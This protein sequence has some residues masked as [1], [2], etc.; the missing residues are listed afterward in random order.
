MTPALTAAIVRVRH[1]NGAI[2]G[3]GFL[4]GDGR[5]LTCAHV[6]ADALGRERSDPQ[7]P[8]AEVFLDFPLLP[9][10]PTASAHVEVWRPLGP[11]GGND[12][13][14]GDI[15]VLELLHP[16]PIAAQ[17][18]RRVGAGN[19]WRRR[20]GAFGFP[21]DSGTYTYGHCLGPQ[22]SGWIHVESTSEY[23][24]EG[25]YSGTPAWDD[26]RDLVI[27]MV[28]ATEGADTVKAG[29]VI[30]ASALADLCPGL[31]IV[32]LAEK[33]GAAPAV[34]VPRAVFRAPPRNSI[35]TGREQLLVNLEAALVSGASTAL[36]QAITGLGGAGKTQVAIEYAHR[37]R[38]HYRVIWWVRAESPETLLE[39]LAALATPLGLS[40]PPDAPPADIAAAVRRALEDNPGWLLVFDNAESLDVVR[41]H[42]PDY[43]HVLITS[44]NRAW[45][46]GAKVIQVDVWSPQEAVTFLLTRTGQS[47]ADGAAALAETL[48]YLPLAL[49]Q[50]G[51]YMEE[52]AASFVRYLHLYRDR[53]SAKLLAQHG[54]RDYA[55]TVATTW[56]L[57][58]DQ[59][60]KASPA[61]AEL[62][63]LCAFLTPEAI[64]EGLFRPEERSILPPG[65]RRADDEAFDNACGVLCRYSLVQ[66]NDGALTLHRLVQEVVRDGLSPQRLRTRVTAGVLLVRTAFPESSDD[67][68][69]WGRCARLLP[70][71]LTVADHAEGMAA[72]PEAT[73]WLL[74]RVATYLWRRAE[75]TPARRLFERALTIDEAAYGP[76]HPSV[77]EHVN[78]LALVLLDLGDLA[79]ARRG[80]ERAL[81][82]H[83]ATYGP[84]HPTVATNINNLALVLKALGHL[85]EARRDLE[86]A[87][88]ID[89]AAYGP[90]HPTVARDVNNLARVLHDLGDMAGAR[91][92]FE[93]ALA[94]DEAAFG[95]DHPSVARDVNNLAVVLRNLG[96]LAKARR[97]AERALAI[98]E[99]A[100]GPDH[101]FV[102]STVDTRA[103]VLRDLG[104]LAGARRGFERALAIHEAAYGPDH[105]SVATDVN[106][107]ARVLQE[108]GDLA[109][110]R[111]GFER[112]L[113]IITAA[114]GPDHPRAV[115]I[116]QNLQALDE[117]PPGSPG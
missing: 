33:E 28:V 92:G 20:F 27:G 94:I 87:L 30:P 15:A 107:L 98:D 46:A 58:F 90:D 48:G 96:E 1:A 31:E 56:R 53:G 86:R 51:A 82:I 63:E 105:P 116:A 104:E 9:G 74:D 54:P 37:H 99:A 8:E 117:D 57:S 5:V 18:I 75:V 93:R 19:L 22:A 89:E 76:D 41:D 85:A 43:G 72:E 66:R 97:C 2:V 36:V 88:A 59:V 103:A 71:A 113:R 64:P 109:G 73:S 67:V 35:F 4:V 7:R 21:T 78:N 83:K 44:R 101:P 79:G 111:R 16:P 60:R 52:R 112:A 91:R 6:V 25:G 55:G 77:A 69:T 29:W 106:N 80:F 26:E 3:G 23:R 34:G 68:R 11:G 108:L 17:P 84:D 40:V 81:A 24:I 100:F 42:L 50:A 115:T 110:A 49:E 45:R 39:D 65:L 13:G 10:A 38:N 62:L 32:V 114:W 47:D 61:A 102:A 95:P 14:Q 12:P 70:H